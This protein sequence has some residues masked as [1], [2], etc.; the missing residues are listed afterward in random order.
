MGRTDKLEALPV[1][2]DPHAKAPHADAELDADLDMQVN[3]CQNG[4]YT[5]YVHV[6]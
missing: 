2:T 6:A 1:E 3:Y 4:S 5:P